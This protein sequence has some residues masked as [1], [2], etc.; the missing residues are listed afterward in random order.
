METILFCSFWLISFPL[1]N[2]LKPGCSAPTAPAEAPN[3]E[4]VVE[5]SKAP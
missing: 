3:V 5:D 2:N 1:L 4:V